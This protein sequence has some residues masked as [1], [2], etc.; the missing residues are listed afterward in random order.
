[1]LGVVCHSGV[2][3]VD[4]NG[5]H[6]VRVVPYSFEQMSDVEIDAILDRTVVSIVIRVEVRV[7]A[8]VIICFHFEVRLGYKG[9]VPCYVGVIAIVMRVRGGGGEG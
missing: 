6:S 4:C 1:M 9:H 7:D 2:V 8:E 5:L 3:K